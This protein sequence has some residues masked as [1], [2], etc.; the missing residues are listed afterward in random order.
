IL[1]GHSTP[2]IAVHFQKHHPRLISFSKGSELRVWDLQLQV[3]IQKLNGIYPKRIEA[4]INTL[5]TQI[6]YSTLFH[7]DKK[8][9]F[10]AFNEILTVMEIK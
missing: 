7:E 2:V 6:C 5:R 10:I 4:S 9:L 8:R 3:C 1:R